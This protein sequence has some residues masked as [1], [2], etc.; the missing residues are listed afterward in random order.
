VD[1]LNDDD[2]RQDFYFT[3]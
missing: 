1:E 2:M 3:S